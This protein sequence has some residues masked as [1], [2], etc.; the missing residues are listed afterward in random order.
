[1]KITSYLELLKKQRRL[2]TQQQISAIQEQARL[3]AIASEKMQIRDRLEERYRE[4]FAKGFEKLSTAS[5]VLELLPDCDTDADRLK[6]LIDCTQD[7]T[8]PFHD[9]TAAM[10]T[11]AATMTA[12]SPRPPATSRYMCHGSRAYPS[13]L[14][15]SSGIAA[16]RAAWRRRSSRCTW[17]ASLCA[18][19]RTSPRR[20]GAA[21]FRPPPSA[22]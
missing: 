12:I 13:R 2:M 1:M 4:V 17:Q 14:P 6:A 3:H 22:S 10:K 20:C 7:G 16:G 11:I 15:S 8:A 21:R 19:W 18:G 9:I 5:N